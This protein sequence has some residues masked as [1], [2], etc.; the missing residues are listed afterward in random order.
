MTQRAADLVCVKIG[1]CGGI[2]GALAAASRARA[3][4]YEVYLASTLDG[5]L[6]IAAALHAAAAIGPG[7]ACGLATLALFEGRP[8]PL[9]PDRGTIAVPG[10]PGLGDAL[11]EW[12]SAGT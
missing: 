1:R 3:A 9:P 7:R 12:Y 11:A 10:T 6:G 2:S 4:G 8:D 5:P